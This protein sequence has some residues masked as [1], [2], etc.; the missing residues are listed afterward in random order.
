[1]KN[2]LS[3]LFFKYKEK[4]NSEKGVGGRRRLYNSLWALLF[5]VLTSVLVIAI[6]GN[7]PFEVFQVIFQDATNQEVRFITTTVVFIIATLGTAMCFKSGIFNIGISGQM[8]AGGITSIL[9]LKLVGVNGGTI[10]MSIILSMIS[11]ALVA[12]ITGV[13]KAFLKVN[14]VVSTI[15]LNWIVFYVIKFIIQSNIPGLVT[16]VSISQN[17]TDAI[18]MPIFFQSGVWLALL[19][20]FGIIMIFGM[21]FLFSKTTIGYKMKMLALN[22]D[23]SKYAG[24]NEKIILI[25]IMTISGALSGL[26]GFLYYTEIGVIS[27]KSEPISMGFDTIAIA[28]LVYNNP[29]GIGISSILFA[30]I[31]LGC[32]ALKPLFPPLTEDFAQIMFGV[33]IYIAAI[34]V[35]FEKFK[36]YIYIKNN[37]IYHQDPNYKEVLLTYYK[38]KKT[39]FTTRK[40]NNIII[41]N[42]KLSNSKL[43]AETRKK[44]I[45]KKE[46]LDH[47]L[48]GKKTTLNNL[49]KEQ[50]EYYLAQRKNNSIIKNI[51]LNNFKLWIKIIKES[52]QN[53]HN[54]GNEL[55]ITTS[56]LNDLSEEQK[57]YYF[58]EITLIKKEK[59]NELFENKY[60]EVAALKNVYKSLK[61]D[62]KNTLNEKR[63]E[64][65]EAYNIKVQEKKILKG[66]E[67][68]NGNI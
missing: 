48:F 17:Q 32:G 29:F 15:L 10:T 14:E 24:S 41:K 4:F 23:A 26:A 60:F 59:D 28:L 56:S 40:N 5:G 16:S 33:I 57:E 67:G 36:I 8:M 19:S 22:K 18:V 2:K 11:G 50:K 49:S 25:S 30:I 51:K 27:A 37:Y 43:W 9:I 7:N 3:P 52:I 39:I 42:I 58:E 21:W 34:G 62:N 46:E 13:L 44:S 31:K 6:T 55:F 68:K 1:M 47:E 65:L 45:Q 35:V 63:K 12:G 64:I 61:N 53:N 20:I 54:L 66:R 38:T